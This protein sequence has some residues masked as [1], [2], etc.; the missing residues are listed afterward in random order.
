M[1]RSAYI[2]DLTSDSALKIKSENAGTGKSIGQNLDRLYR[3]FKKPG[4]ET[5]IVT[6]IVAANPIPFNIAN[7]NLTI[8]DNHQIDTINTDS[9]DYKVVFYYSLEKSPE[10][11]PPSEDLLALPENDENYQTFLFTL[12]QGIGGGKII[13]DFS[14]NKIIPNRGDKIKIETVKGD[15]AYPSRIIDIEQAEQK[16]INNI[17][18]ADTS[19]KEKAKENPKVDPNDRGD[20]EVPGNDNKPPIAATPDPKTGLIPWVNIPT[21]ANVGKKIVNLRTDAAEAY[22]KIYKEVKKL[23]GKMLVSGAGRSL[24]RTAGVGASKSSLHY[25][26][27]A[28]DIAISTGLKNPESDPHIVTVDEKNRWVVWFRTKNKDIPEIELDAIK[29]EAKPTDKEKNAG[30]GLS[31]KKKIKARVFNFTEIAEKH[32]FSRIR[33]WDRFYKIGGPYDESEWWHFQFLAGL[34]A[35]ESI[36]GEEML[37]VYPKE[38]AEKFIYW[39]ESKNLQWTGHNFREI[40]KMV[41]KVNHEKKPQKSKKA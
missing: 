8:S 36:Y 17:N 41:A 5:V 38:V 20:V 4:S 28:F 37:L 33:A 13:M 24:E 31:Q 39:N 26:G 23:G 29:W 14:K 16:A 21:E 1:S 40:K 12:G 11:I 6:G 27:R 9:K 32:G 3:N 25:I 22:M 7:A 30:T 18:Q 15:M 35:G 2:T 34:R 10:V 19:L